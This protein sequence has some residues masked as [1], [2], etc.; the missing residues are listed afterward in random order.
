MLFPAD[1]KLV[2]SSRNEGFCLKKNTFS[3]EEKKTAKSLWQM[4]KKIGCH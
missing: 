2:S 1:K 3:L 4:E